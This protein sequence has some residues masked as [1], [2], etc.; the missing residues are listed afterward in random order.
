M[1]SPSTDALPAAAPRR[2]ATRKITIP[3]AVLRD[4]P[5]L[6]L[7]I[8]LLAAARFVV[9][10]GF[11]AVM[12]FLAMHLAVERQIPILRI[13]ALWTIVGLTSA[14]MQWVAGELT[15]R[16][17]RRRLLLAAM[18]MR[19]LNLAALGF[20]IGAHAPF[21]VIGVLCVINGAMRAFYDP[22]AS[23]VVAELCSRDERVAAFSLHRVGSSLGWAAGPL[24]VTFARETSYSAFFYAAAPITLLAAGAVALIPRSGPLMPRPPLRWAQIAEFRH[25]A[26]F[27]RFLAATLAFFVLQTQMYHMLPI[28]AAKTLGLDRAQVGTL[29]VANGLLVVVVQLPAVRFIRR[30]GTAGALVLGSLGYLLAYGGVAAARGYL[31]LFACVLVATLCEIVAVPAHQARLTA[32]APIDNVASYAGIAGLVQGL[33]QTTGPLVGSFLVALLPSGLGWLLFAVFGTAAALGFRRQ[34]S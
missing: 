32:L 22:A 9:T 14:S 18:V 12:P 21:L 23:A 33:A 24:C 5:A 17:G 30:V 31:S 20:A 13:G 4:F 10:A 16:L 2:T 6:D 27:M 28:Y 11:A 19:S 25:D 29:F 7:R 1:A 8:W 15:G 26:K 3:V 34:R